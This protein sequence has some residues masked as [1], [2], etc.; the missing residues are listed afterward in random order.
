MYTEQQLCCEE[1]KKKKSYAQNGGVMGRLVLVPFIPGD[2]ALWA[3]Q[4]T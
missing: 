1:K 2:L 4:H 3:A